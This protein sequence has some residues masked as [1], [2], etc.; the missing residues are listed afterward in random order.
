MLLRRYTIEIHRWVSMLPIPSYLRHSEAMSSK[1]SPIECTIT[2]KTKPFAWIEESS[3]KKQ[4][5]VPV[6]EKGF[7][8]ENG[9]RGCRDGYRGR[10]RGGDERRLFDSNVRQSYRLFDSLPQF[11]PV[12][13]KQQLAARAGLQVP[14]VS[15]VL[16]L[17]FWLLTTASP[18]NNNNA[19]LD[20]QIKLLSIYDSHVR[21]MSLLAAPATPAEHSALSLNAIYDFYYQFSA[22][23]N[24]ASEHCEMKHIKSLTTPTLDGNPSQDSSYPGT[25]LISSSLL[26]G[27]SFTYRRRDGGRRCQS[28]VPPWTT[29]LNVLVG[30]GALGVTLA[31]GLDVAKVTDSCSLVYL[32]S[33]QLMAF[34]QIRLLRILTVRAG[35]GVDVHATLGVGVVT[36]D[37]DSCSKTTEP[38]LGTKVSELIHPHLDKAPPPPFLPPFED[39][40]FSPWLSPRRER[41]EPS[42]F[43]PN[44]STADGARNTRMDDKLG[45]CSPTS[46]QNPLNPAQVRWPTRK[47]GSPLTILNDFFVVLWVGIGFVVLREKG[48]DEGSRCKEGKKGKVPYGVSET[49]QLR[50]GNTGEEKRHTR[51]LNTSLKMDGS[52]TANGKGRAPTAGLHEL[53][54]RPMRNETYRSSPRLAFSK[55]GGVVLRHLPYPSS[56]ILAGIMPWS[57]SRLR[58][59]ALS[60]RT[61]GWLLVS[62]KS[63]CRILDPASFV[64]GHAVENE[65]EEGRCSACRLLNRYRKPFQLWLEQRGAVGNTAHLI[66]RKYRSL[67]I[68]RP[69]PVT[70]K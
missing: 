6:N 1:H 8:K 20:F 56:P 7:G 67:F 21:V 58:L 43:E 36:A 66:V 10:E 35:G 61:S 42:E 17:R 24:T 26:G 27:N 45:V 48:N 39:S 65:V 63:C 11:R 64:L 34:L 46:F 55:H 28:S 2:A 18:L 32:A 51:T 23:F 14:Y 41:R 3:M 70:R 29:T 31:I 60:H 33:H 9:E 54:G 19:S 25:E 53:C 22:A 15:K 16:H 49:G 69:R 37:S 30:D 4:Q 52:L 40:L 12:S 62:Q 68:I 38:R 50:R 59:D 5:N 13:S 44:G 57:K 47:V